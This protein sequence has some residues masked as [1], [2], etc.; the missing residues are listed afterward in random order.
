MSQITKTLTSGGPIPPVI[1]TQ[2]TTDAGIAVPA[3]NNINVFGGTGTSTAASG[4]TITI[5]VKNEGF[6]WSEQNVSF[7]ASVQNGYFCNNALTVTLPPTAGLTIGN[8]VIIYVDTVGQVIIQA[9]TGQFIQVGSAISVSGGVADSNTR[10]AILEL[11]FK[12][13][14]LTWHTQ[15]SLGVWAIT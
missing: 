9:N 15:S 1:P 14:D 5:T 7:S 6:T 10:G 11:I 8:T 13:S 2:F 3:A 4:S 12:P